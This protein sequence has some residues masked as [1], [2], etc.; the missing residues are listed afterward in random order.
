MDGVE[1]AE[2]GEFDE[3]REKRREWRVE[4]VRCEV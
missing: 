2:E 4:G 1:A 3:R